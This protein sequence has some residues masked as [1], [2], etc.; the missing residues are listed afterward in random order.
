MTGKRTLLE[1]FEALGLATNI[2][3]MIA[4][5]AAQ[6][7]VNMPDITAEELADQAGTIRKC[8]ERGAQLQELYGIAPPTITEIRSWSEAER[9]TYLNT[10]VETIKKAAGVTKAK[11]KASN[12]D[13]LV[14]ALADL[15]KPYLEQPLDEKKVREIATDVAQGVVGKSLTIT[16]QGPKG[17]PVTINGAHK[18]MPEILY[19][20]DKGKHVYLHGL[21]GG[22]KTTIARQ[23]ADALQR[24]FGYMML[25]AM[26]SPA[27]VLGFFNAN[28]G[29]HMTPFRELY[30]KEALLCIDEL[31]N[32]NPNTLTTINGPIENGECQF[33]D[34]L[35]KLHPMFK[36]I[37]TGNTAARGGNI[38]HA[39]RQALDAA[40]LD[41][42]VCIDFAYDLDLEERMVLAVAPTNGQ[43]VLKWVRDVRAWVSKND[44]KLVVSP[45]AAVN[46]AVGSEDAPFDNETLV[47]HALFKGF[48]PD[49]TR[50]L[51]KNVPIPA[52]VRS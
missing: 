51:L 31:D 39:G 13:Q 24:E 1:K 46:I 26:T 47:Q 12:D 50:T 5:L 7:G 9:Q 6:K 29:F 11:P 34:G 28:G 35:L 48:N 45:R 22:G 20:I 23:V 42:F 32:C 25:N 3:W 10:P 36:I 4:A 17:K 18:Q 2:N 21:P 14:T 40:T 16:V 15:L 52:W 30:T 38:M 37:A 33:P 49:S 27:Q 8:R 41:R 44:V 43:Q 19:W